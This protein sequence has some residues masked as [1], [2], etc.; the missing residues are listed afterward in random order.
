[1]MTMAMLADDPENPMAGSGW[2]RRL[3]PSSARA[4]QAKSLGI[5]IRWRQTHDGSPCDELGHDAGTQHRW[6]H[7]IDVAPDAYL[8]LGLKRTSTRSD[9][10][11]AI[12]SGSLPALLDRIAPQPGD[13]FYIG[14][15]MLCALGPGLELLEIGDAGEPSF[16]AWDG[17]LSAELHSRVA[18][19]DAKFDPR[20]PIAFPPDAAPF[21]LTLVEL[22][23]GDNVCV[24]PE[25][26]CLAIISGSGRLGCQEFGPREVWTVRGPLA[27]AARE[28]TT[29]IV[30]ER[31]PS[32]CAPNLDAVE[33]MTDGCGILQRGCSVI[34]DRRHGYHLDANARA[35]ILT[36]ELLGDKD[37]AHRA[38]RLAATFAAFIGHAFDADGRRFRSVMN[39][40]RRWADGD[41]SLES[42]WHALWALGRTAA[43]A[44]DDGLTQW[45]S[46]LLDQA[47]GG[48][49][50]PTTPRSL[51][52]AALGAAPYLKT[53]PDHALS[54][55]FLEISATRLLEQL[56]ENRRSGWDW[57]APV[58]G[59][60]AARLPEALLRAGTMLGRPDMRSAGLAALEWLTARQ[61]AEE[62][63]FRPLTAVPSAASSV[64][65]EPAEQRPLD[66]WASIDACACGFEATRD[67]RWIERAE[68]AFAWYVGCNDLGLR[69]ATA[70]G[71]CLAGLVAGGASPDQ[72]AES[73]LA[74]QF[75]NL[76]IHRLRAGA[77][78][79]K[80][81]PA[82]TPDAAPPQE[83]Q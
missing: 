71:G 81:A 25:L 66:V 37:E 47:L 10:E 23:P 52:Y 60:D 36:A 30:A 8:D 58:L 46:Q 29:I 65:A 53:C 15:G 67:P 5:T 72:G 40:D 32:V 76:A 38:R 61:T 3:A 64:E 19:A 9:I 1:M 31:R 50:E 18:P 43:A 34:P 54:R 44:H 4:F 59:R 39:Y 24:V 2:A 55:R 77:K 69:L 33:R 35:L 49:V 16:Q 7:V 63:F 11:K 41:A 22:G 13:S 27:L 70:D 17:K 26:A 45:A 56:R 82:S 62:G 57:F 74:F 28:A 80:G 14:S 79:Q 68:N 12:R 20:L 75:S 51:A 73:I 21:A 42:F 83:P 78:A 48:A 6:W